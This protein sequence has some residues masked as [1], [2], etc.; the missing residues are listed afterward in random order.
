MWHTGKGLACGAIG[1]CLISGR[2]R[3]FV[4]PILFCIRMAHYSSGE[5]GWFSV[6]TLSLHQCS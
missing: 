1:P 5:A 4:E 2:A 6:R 3:D